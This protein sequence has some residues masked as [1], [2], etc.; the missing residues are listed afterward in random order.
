[1]MKNCLRTGALLLIAAF[2]CL[3]A[4]RTVPDAAQAAVTLLYFQGQ[5]NGDS[6][7]LEWATATELNTAYFYLERADA[8][9]GPYQMLDGIG[10]VPSEAPP[11]GLSG[12]EYQRLDDDNVSAGQAYWYT[13]VEVESVQGTENRTQPIRVALGDAQ[14]TNTPTRTPT[15]APTAT[16]TVAISGSPTATATA[17]STAQA[18]PTATPILARTVSTQASATPEPTGT[19]L[20]AHTADDIVDTQ[21]ETLDR[22][23][24]TPTA[25]TVGY[26]A[27]DTEV[28][29]IALQSDPNG[30]P[31]AP[32]TEQV[33]VTKSYPEPPGPRDLTNGDGTP[34]PNIGA[35]SQAAAQGRLDESQ[36]PDNSPAL[37]TLF[38]W[39]GFA[40]ALIVF[41][42]AVVGAVYFYSRQRAAKK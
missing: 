32:P 23:R 6:V 36:P 17:T 42:S 35:N 3:A 27:P 5:H 21:D 1:M 40:A 18:G 12:A 37:G 29:V 22:E 41:I 33:F 34:V 25:P 15:L 10:L 4:L 26:P 11:D 9:D 24:T 31:A 14:P 30:Y 8:Q 39:L 28:P 13:L 2:A 38:L 7:L 19:T 20:A 16:A